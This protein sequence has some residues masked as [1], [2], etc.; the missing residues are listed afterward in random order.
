ME[1][2]RITA[3]IAAV[4]AF[5]ASAGCG[6]DGGTSGTSDISGLW[7]FRF[8]VA[9]GNVE[10]GGAGTMTL[11]QT[12]T[13]VSGDGAQTSSCLDG[14]TGV[15]SDGSAAFTLANG[16]LHGSTLDFDLDQCAFTG[17]IQGKNLLRAVGTVS[18]GS[19]P[20][21]TGTWHAERGGDGAPPGPIGSVSGPNGDTLVVADEAVILAGA[22]D[23]RALAWVGY[24]LGPPIDAADSAPATGTQLITLGT[25]GGPL[26]RADR[27]QSSNLLVVNGALYLIDAG[28]SVTSRV[29]QSGHDFRKIGKIF[30]THPHSDHTA[31]P[32]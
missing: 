25:A 11:A 8:E 13:T 24:R 27:A 3:L 2:H 7:A 1:S 32:R 23:D 18:C 20:S 6:D 10:C 12:G 26:P 28:G 16:E 19:A 5:G 31:W 21:L 9:Q 4:A 14:S 17:T 30:I 15:L 29:V 22:T